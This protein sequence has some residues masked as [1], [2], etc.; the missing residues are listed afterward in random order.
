MLKRKSYGR[1]LISVCNRI[2]NTIKSINHLLDAAIGYNLLVHTDLSDK[3][4]HGRKH[5]DLKKNTV[6]SSLQRIKQPAS[7]SVLHHLV[8]IMK[9]LL[10]LRYHFANQ[11]LVVYDQKHQ[12]P[13]VNNNVTR[14]SG[15][16]P[17]CLQN[18][19]HQSLKSFILKYKTV[20]CLVNKTP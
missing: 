1:F 16:D 7:Y 10:C 17:F 2:I 12:L 13:M 19:K 9:N 6:L 8:L 15:S 18:P 4:S 5:Y 3:L 14:L 11:K 20:G